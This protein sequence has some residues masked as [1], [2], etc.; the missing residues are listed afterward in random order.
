MV[1]LGLLI[2]TC[3]IGILFMSSGDRGGPYGW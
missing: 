3:T 1:V 2:A